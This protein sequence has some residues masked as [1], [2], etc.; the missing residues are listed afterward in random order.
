LRMFWISIMDAELL[1]Q[2][3][4]TCDVEE[5]P[6]RWCSYTQCGKATL[7]N[8]VPM[9]VESALHDQEK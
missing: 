4:P 1:K 2:S 5:D 7:A 9:G 3:W 8:C 6:D